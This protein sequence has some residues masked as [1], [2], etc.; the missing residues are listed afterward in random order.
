MSW[1][2]WKVWVI[3]KNKED[4]ENR[5]NHIKKSQYKK[6]IILKNCAICKTQFITNIDKQ[7]ICLNP[8][9]R[10]IAK[11]QDRKNWRYGEHITNNKKRLEHKIKMASRSIV[12]E[13]RP[14]ILRILKKEC[15]ICQSKEKLE[16]HHMRYKIFNIKD[17][18]DFCKDL[19]VM[20]GSCHPRGKEN[21]T[22]NQSN[23]SL[24]QLNQ[25]PKGF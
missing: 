12:R 8:N 5:K 1:E 11:K 10:K 9:C 4:Y 15:C 21:V 7:K 14:E 24:F 3:N 19:K 13:F 20:C 22:T 17:L 6:N 16:I 25:K 2:E 18:K 23:N